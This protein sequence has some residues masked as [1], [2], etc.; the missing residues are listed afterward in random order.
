M[1]VLKCV[2]IFFL[3]LQISIKIILSEKEL[4]EQGPIFSGDVTPQMVACA[5]FTQNH[6]QQVVLKSSLVQML[7]ASIFIRR[8]SIPLP[9]SP[10]LLGKQIHGGLLENRSHGLV[11]DRVKLVPGSCYHLRGEQALCLPLP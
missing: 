2:T 11:L 4:E 1:W 10:I 9:L 3:L 7:V 6:S 8:P 5:I